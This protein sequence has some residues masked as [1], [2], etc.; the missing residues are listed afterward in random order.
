LIIIY[1][2]FNLYEK[3]SVMQAISSYI[4]SSLF[5]G[6]SNSLSSVLPSRITLATVG[7]AGIIGGS[8]AGLPGV[9][10]GVIVGASV[11]SLLNEGVDTIKVGA[12]K[13]TEGVK[14]AYHSTVAWVK[15]SIY[16]LLET[17]FGWLA[18]WSDTSDWAQSIYAY[19]DEAYLKT[20]SG[21]ELQPLLQNPLP[22]GVAVQAD[23]LAALY[24]QAAFSEQP[25]TKQ[26]IKEWVT[27]G[28]HIVK[29][30]TDS[31]CHLLAEGQEV[32][33]ANPEGGEP[34]IV[35]SSL[36]NVRAITWYVTAQALWHA[37]L[38]QQSAGKA[39]DKEALLKLAKQVTNSSTFVVPDKEGSLYTFISKAP[40][41]YNDTGS[42]L[43]KQSILY[44]ARQPHLDLQN[45]MPLPALDDS[46]RH[47]PAKARRLMVNQLKDSPGVPQRLALQLQ[48]LPN[49]STTGQRGERHEPLVWHALQRTTGFATKVMTAIDK[50]D[51]RPDMQEKTEQQ[52]RHDALYQE[53]ERVLDKTGLP[54]EELKETMQQLTQLSLI[55][56]LRL[57]QP[58]E[59]WTREQVKLSTQLRALS[60]TDYNEV[61]MKLA[62]AIE[63]EAQGGWDEE[64]MRE[65][66]EIW[67]PIHLE[68][69]EALKQYIDKNKA[70]LAEQ[71]ALYTEVR[72]PLSE[73][74]LNAGLELATEVA[75]IA[76]VSAFNLVTAGSEAMRGLSAWWGM[77]NS[78]QATEKLLEDVLEASAVHSESSDSEEENWL[79]NAHI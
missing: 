5:T 40:S 61:R 79:D 72:I 13:I 15:Q 65:N 32:Q 36:Y 66:D 45:L 20:P 1:L 37:A 25:V 44:N 47:L 74:L 78:T 10:L 60:D 41:C 64:A 77:R 43:N 76:G 34:I 3:E 8:L 51:S 22:E 71:L 26:N 69:K 28:E 24:A 29:A 54:E 67:V 31:A 9:A 17:A 18:R 70:D 23:I 50:W 12:G 56:V 46:S 11:N 27:L 63:E 48:A 52:I 68:T 73:Q 16:C 6:M 55:A 33:V 30:L 75:V 58:S 4:G 59:D 2:F 21:I 35:E 49:P 14:T 38:Q 42:V 53:L 57:F 39:S 19:T 7:T 62:Q